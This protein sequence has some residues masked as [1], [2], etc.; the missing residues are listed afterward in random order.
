MYQTEPRFALL[1]IGG[2][3]L[4]RRQRRYRLVKE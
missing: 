1:A 4:R 3:L 2:L